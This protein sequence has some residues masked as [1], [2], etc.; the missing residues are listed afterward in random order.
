L[1]SSHGSTHPVLTDLEIEAL[2]TLHERVRALVGENTA[3]QR[4]L[5]CSL[6]R[7]G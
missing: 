4:E 5:L 3:A 7:S 6:R 1:Y 2:G